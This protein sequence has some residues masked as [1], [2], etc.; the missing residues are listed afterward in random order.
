MSFSHF[1]GGYIDTKHPAKLFCMILQDSGV[2]IFSLK[3]SPLI[4]G[5]K[6]DA[7]SL[8]ILLTGCGV[9]CREC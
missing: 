5:G 2:N 1:H 4:I 8:S 7:T 9:T 3:Y 6:V